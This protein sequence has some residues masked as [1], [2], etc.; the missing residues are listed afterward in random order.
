M[1]T[2]LLI[3]LFLTAT[4]RAADLPTVTVEHL[5]Y[6][7]AR[8]ERVRKFKPDEM[9]DYCI[10]QKIGGNAF[11]NLY[12]QLF[13]LRID[14]TKLLRVEEVLS[15]DP[16]VV[17]LNKTH[18]AYLTL[19]R[20]EAQKVQSGIVHEGQVATDTMTAIARSQNPR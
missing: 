5:Y 2:Y 17:I 6:L 9:I 4:L 15:T 11:E 19:L 14:L 10:A 12:A 7:Q 1:K 13:T 20:E 16:R 3:A 18:D 8:A